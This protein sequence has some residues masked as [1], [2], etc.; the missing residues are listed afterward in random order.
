M[1]TRPKITAADL[2]GIIAYLVTPIKEGADRR[3]RGAVKVD[4]AARATDQMVKDGISGFCLN[5]T[6]GEA[7]SHFPLKAQKKARRGKSAYTRS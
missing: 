2:K 3:S 7:R 1:Q 6:F 4:E 5:G